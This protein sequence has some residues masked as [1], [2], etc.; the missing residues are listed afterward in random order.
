MK[1]IAAVTFDLWDTL[2]QEVPGGSD[3]VANARID[4]IS[5]YLNDKGMVH[6]R[7]EVAS[8]YDK[9]GDFL[10]LTW[11]K[12]R[13]MPVRDQILFLLAGI[14]CKLTGRL[15]R[16]DIEHIERIYAEGILEHP[17]KL[18]P[19][20]MEGIREVRSKG[21]KMGLISNTGRTPGSILRRV[22]DNMGILEFFD[23][24]TFSNEILV[25]KPS[26]GAF[27]VT[28]ESLRVVPKAAVHVGDDATSDIAGARNVGMH[29]VHIVA[30]GDEPSALAD[31]QVESLERVLESIERL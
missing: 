20:A 8:A 30:N 9:T 1:R 6:T 4:R 7:L 14:D 16:E 22:M 12:K 2:I 19:G 17:P 3:R 13:D 27:I 11:S 21:Y 24:T 31:A 29:T 10:E 18:L 28:L 15:S 25:R 23:T 5:R 26:E